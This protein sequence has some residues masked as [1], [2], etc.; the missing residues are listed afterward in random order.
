MRGN[1]NKI[2]KGINYGGFKC[3]RVFMMMIEVLFISASDSR[4]NKDL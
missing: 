1:F 3:N 4:F 2:K